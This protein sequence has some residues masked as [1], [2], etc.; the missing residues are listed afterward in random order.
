M[1]K[2]DFENFLLILIDE[3]KKKQAIVCANTPSMYLRS[4]NLLVIEITEYSA[5]GR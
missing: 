4:R 5:S 1:T 3:D 2:G